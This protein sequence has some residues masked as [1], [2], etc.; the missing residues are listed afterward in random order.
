VGC[1]TG[2]ATLP[3]APR[4]FHIT[5][6]EPGANLAAQARRNLARFEHVQIVESG[7]ETW[8]P[9]RASPPFDLVFA[10]TAWHWVDPAVRYRRAWEMLSANGHLAFWDARHVIPPGGDPFF[11][12][13]QEVYEEIGA[14]GPGPRGGPAPG[15][16]PERRDEIEASG[17]FDV[18]DVRHFDWE[19]TYDVDGYIDLLQTFSGHI[20]ME[21]WQRER[22]YGEIRRRLGMR[23]PPTL[24]RHWGCVLHLAR[25][26]GLRAR[27]RTS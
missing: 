11:A 16:L 24:R 6:V 12:E 15:E 8:A 20:A 13:I 19:L 10:A 22:L 3:L 9:S 7:F 14:A 27:P 25:R 2:K 17:L 23:R 5:C 4:G 26:A 18:V 1:G 21:P